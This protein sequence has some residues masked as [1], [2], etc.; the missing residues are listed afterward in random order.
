M[1]PVTAP[2]GPSSKVK[3]TIFLLPSAFFP[4]WASLMPSGRS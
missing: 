1:W 2:L 4:S 3:A